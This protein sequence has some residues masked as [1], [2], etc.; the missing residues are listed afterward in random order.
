MNLFSRLG[1]LGVLFTALIFMSA[2]FSAPISAQ[3]PTDSLQLHL[4]ASLG[5]SITSDSVN[6]WADQ[7]GKGNDAFQNTL[8]RRPILVTN[9]MNGEPGIRF[10]GVDSYLTLPTAADLGIQNSDYEIFIVSRS[11]T[12]NTNIVFLLAGNTERYE[13]HLN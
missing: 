2:A 9:S 3:I 11:A 7:S 13:L 5:V 4:N 10:N 6:T 8:A 1:H 12:I